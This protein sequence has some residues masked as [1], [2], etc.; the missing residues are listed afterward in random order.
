MTVRLP[1]YDGLAPGTLP[2]AEQPALIPYPAARPGSAAVLVCPGGGYWL[3]APH[4][5][6]PIARWLTSLGL[7]SGVVHYRCAP[8]RHPVPLHDAQRAVRL[9]RA[10][11]AS[12]NVDPA[13]IGILGFSAGGHLAASVANFGADGDPASADPVERESARVQALVACYA[14]L[15]F[16]P[17]GHQ[18]SADNLLGAD[19]DPALRTRLSLEHSVTAANPPSFLWHTADDQAVPVE[20]ALLYA[21]ALRASRVSVALHVYPHGAHGIGLAAEHPGSASGW[22][23][24]C[25]DWLG[26]IGFRAALTSRP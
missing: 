19:A 8:H 25:A 1:L 22:T 17:S 11:A 10:R 2:G 26:E 18:G 9:M 23:R 14:V 15:S 24:A 5:A 3:R 12:W 13:R 20:N 6:D 16:G 4:E 21:G 7:A